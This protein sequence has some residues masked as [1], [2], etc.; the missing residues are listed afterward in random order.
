MPTRNICLAASHSERGEKMRFKP[1]A[2]LTLEK[3][4]F[5]G[6]K[7]TRPRVWAR[8]ISRARAMVVRTAGARQDRTS[9]PPCSATAMSVVMLGRL[10]ASP[11][12]Y[13]SL[14]TET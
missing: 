14:S 10:M 13:Q 5:S 2:G 6:L 4:G 7:V 1:L 12:L 11:T 9:F 3:L 8:F